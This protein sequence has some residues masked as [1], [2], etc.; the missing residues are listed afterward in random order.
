MAR[1]LIVLADPDYTYLAP[2]ELRFLEEL[3]GRVDLE[4]ITDEAYLDE[5]LS[6]PHDIEALLVDEGWFDDR[7]LLQNVASMLVLTESRDTDRTSNL[8]ADYTFKYT[9]LNLIFN[10]V[11][12]SCPRLRDDTSAG[13][14]TVLLFH[15]PVGGAGTT[16]AAMAVA[17]CLRGSYRRVLYVD[18]E[19]V[20]S[21]TWRLRGSSPAPAEMV[22]SMQRQPRDAYEAA[23]PYLATDCFDYVP[24]VRPSL[25]AS[26]IEP[27]IF[28]RLVESARVSGDYDY[29]V[30]DTPA[31]LSPEVVELIGLADRVVVMVTQDE[32]ARHKLACFLSNIDGMDADTY[33]FVCNRYVPAPDGAPLAQAATGVQLDG[34]VER[35]EKISRMDVLQL[36]EVAGFRRL[37]HAL[38]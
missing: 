7:V 32:A 30:V 11:V 1:P 9:S 20:Q 13:E 2:L 3:G 34:F 21:F 12:S 4:V 31:E 17:S 6:S 22:R 28:S 10:K 26:G 5:Y 25:M 33:R 24:A 29:V 19:R 36:G 27:S 35:D 8:A 14:A 37:A 16:T 38:G 15:S 23:R 18:A